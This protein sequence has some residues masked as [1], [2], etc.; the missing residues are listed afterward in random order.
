MMTGGPEPARATRSGSPLLSLIFSKRQGSG[1]LSPSSRTRWRASRKDR[2]QKTVRGILRLILGQGVPPCAHRAGDYFFV[3]LSGG[4]F[5]RSLH[6]RQLGIAD[7]P[8][9]RERYVC[10]REGR[11]NRIVEAKIRAGA[12]CV[13]VEQ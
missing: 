6:R 10:G 7:V 8:E 3:S 4:D 11:G 2:E 1:I 9:L 13:V 12:E 5:G